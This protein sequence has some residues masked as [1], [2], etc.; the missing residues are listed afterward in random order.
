[1]TDLYN[2]LQ[3]HEIGIHFSDVK[4]ISNIIE[5]FEYTCD[6]C[7]EGF[8]TGKE[9]SQHEEEHCECDC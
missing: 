5:Q 8:H 1:M 4:V 9:L 2:H 6:R 3:D 7:D